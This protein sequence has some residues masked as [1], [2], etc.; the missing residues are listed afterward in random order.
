MYCIHEPE[1]SRF[2][3]NTRQHLAWWQLPCAGEQPP[4]HSALLRSLCRE[5]AR[6][7]PQQYTNPGLKTWS[8]QV[9]F[10]HRLCIGF[11]EDIYLFQYL[12][13]T[14]QSHKQNSS[15]FTF[16]TI[17][18]DESLHG[19]SAMLQETS[20]FRR[21]RSGTPITITCL[22]KAMKWQYCNGVQRV[23]S[24]LVFCGYRVQ[25]RTL[26][27]GVDSVLLCPAKAECCYHL[28]RSLRYIR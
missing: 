26:L 28:Q 19:N 7:T 15:S 14:T 24:F 6:T 25:L 8:L 16:R 27:L 13:W 23:G 2:V 11:S 1:R 4:L 12:P 9:T 21:Q 10:L 17:R 5:K 18:T 20:Y 22:R 3:E